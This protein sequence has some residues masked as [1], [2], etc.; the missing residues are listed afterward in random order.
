MIEV[1][2]KPDRSPSNQN[3]TEDTPFYTIDGLQWRVFSRPRTWRPPTDAY[4]IE[5]SLVV[6]VE[7]AGMKE[8]DFSVSLSGRLLSI[9]GIRSELPER[10]AYHQMEISFGEFAIELE[11]PFAIDEN[12]VVAFYQDGFLKISLPK[13]RPHPIKIEG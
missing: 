10:R 9:T 2:F 3:S 1:I 8:E 4:E 5:D 11:A 12:R 7:I 6:R 13:A